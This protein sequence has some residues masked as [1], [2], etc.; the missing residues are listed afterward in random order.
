MESKDKK[1]VWVIAANMGYGHQRTA[2][3]LNEIAFGDK[4]IHANS[5]EGIPIKIKI[6]GKEPG[7]LMSLSQG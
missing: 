3:P 6:S 4:I 2:Y 7:C 1:K 5:Y